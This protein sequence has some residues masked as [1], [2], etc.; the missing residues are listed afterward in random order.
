MTNC[1]QCTKQLSFE[2][3]ERKMIIQCSE[4]NSLW[5]W[6]GEELTPYDENTRHLAGFVKEF[7]IG[8]RNGEYIL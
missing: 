2:L 3:N 6:D 1:P 4:C 7:N 5:D 8:F